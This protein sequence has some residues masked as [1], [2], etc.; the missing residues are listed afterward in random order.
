MNIIKYV[1]YCK[2]NV[3]T[4]PFSTPWK[5]TVFWCFHGVR[6]GCLWLCTP[7]FL[8]AWLRAQ[9]NFATDDEIKFDQAWIDVLFNKK[10]LSIKK[11]FSV[12]NAR[13]ESAGSTFLGYHIKIYYIFF[14]N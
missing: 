6:E 8:Y 4:Q 11:S 1:Y 7:V 12:W 5:L 2:F 14:K 13:M 9:L 10:L 3:L